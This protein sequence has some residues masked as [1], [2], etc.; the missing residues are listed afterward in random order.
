[1][2]VKF[3][4]NKK[5]GSESSIDYLLDER[6]KA[7][8]ARILKGN[9]ELTKNLINT[10]TQKHKICVGC[11]S[12]EESNIEEYLKQEIIESFEYA[13]LTEE[14]Q[15]RYN[16]L[17]VEHRDKGRLELNFVI[18]RIDLAT[19]KA[20]TP[21][22]HKAD[23]PRI[24]AW[25]NL[26]NLEHNFSNPKDPA[27]VQKIQY[28]NTKIPQQKNLFK[29]CQEL[30]D[31]L[32][33]KVK[34]YFLDTRQEIIE[35]LEEHG[36]EVTRQ[37]K[38]YISVKLPES[39]KAIRLK[40][41]IYHEQFG[42]VAKHGSHINQEKAGERTTGTRASQSDHGHTHAD[43]REQTESNYRGNH[44]S[45]SEQVANLREKLQGLIAHKR[46]YYA[47]THT[48]SRT[49]FTDA[50]Y[51][52]YQRAQNHS[53]SNRTTSDHTSAKSGA[54]KQHLNSNHELH[55]NNAFNARRVS[56]FHQAT[57][58]PRIQ[59]KNGEG[60]RGDRQTLHQRTPRTQDE[61]QQTDKQTQ[62][63]DSRVK[64]QTGQAGQETQPVKTVRDKDLKNEHREIERVRMR[65]VRRSR[66]L[67]E[68]NREL[69]RQDQELAGRETSLL[70]AIRAHEES[71]RGARE[72]ITRAHSQISSPRGST[73]ARDTKPY[74]DLIRELESDSERFERQLRGIVAEGADRVRENQS[75]YATSMQTVR[76]TSAARLQR[77]C[78]TAREAIQRFKDFVSAATNGIRDASE[79]LRRANQPE[80]RSVKRR[81]RSK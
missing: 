64:S 11:L 40:G 68:R 58:H 53:Q 19:K 49:H 24:D 13:L 61:V 59:G 34:N 42:N 35:L 14:M 54:E 78:E 80:S 57:L 10:L 2:L 20:F 46:S 33:D 51:T 41:E 77:A 79:E 81:G 66:E 75:G 71:L 16:I 21:Y 12:F 74:S 52:E 9:A 25:K 44:A 50:R 72:T 76:D 3:W 26:V 67:A 1:M 47:T 62:R 4:G 30:D 38:D 28:C 36:I 15:G 45:H 6:F 65:V 39:K 29:D 56:T 70:G 7:G 43:S 5:G 18:P 23:L 73:S 60:N 27:K 37:G 55:P 17:W 8:T 32:H 63:T 22:Y 31:F 69:A 48:E